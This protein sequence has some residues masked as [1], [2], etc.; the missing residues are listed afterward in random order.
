MWSV[1]YD[2]LTEIQRLNWACLSDRQ[3]NIYYRNVCHCYQF[4][5]ASVYINIY[6]VLASIYSSMFWDFLSISW[7][8]RS[9]KIKLFTRPKY[10]YTGITGIFFPVYRYRNF[11]IPNTLITKLLYFWLH[12][13]YIDFKTVLVIIFLCTW[14]KH[15]TCNKIYHSTYAG[16]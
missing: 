7:F 2:G 9:N 14:N 12:S 6:F 11:L 4:V 5:L 13:S 15:N 16:V 8:W 3:R 1:L 10:R